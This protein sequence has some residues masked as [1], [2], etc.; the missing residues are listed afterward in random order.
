MLPQEQI[1]LHLFSGGQF[2][3]GPI[4]HSYGNGFFH[5][6][7]FF[8]ILPCGAPQTSSFLPLWSTSTYPISRKFHITYPNPQHPKPLCSLML[9]GSGT[10][11]KAMVLAI[12][13]LMP[14]GL[15]CNSN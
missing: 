14:G 1:D 9:H 7:L 12:R 13:E 2:F 15:P 8:A 10:E 4:W 11:V 5:F 6:I 3:R